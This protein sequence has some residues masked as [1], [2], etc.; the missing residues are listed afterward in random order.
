MPDLIRT[1]NKQIKEWLNNAIYELK[2][3]SGTI[4]DFVKQ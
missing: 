3:M 2:C 4:E 1:K